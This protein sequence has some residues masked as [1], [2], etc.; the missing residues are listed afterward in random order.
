MFTEIVCDYCD[1]TK[2]KRV[3]DVNRAI[4]KG[5]KLYCDRKCAG[6]ARRKNLSDAEKKD[7]KAVYDANYRRINRDKLRAKKAEWFQRNYDP[8]KA[9]ED[10]AQRKRENPEQEAKR[11]RHMASEGYKRHKKSYDRRYRAHKKYGPEWGDC[12]VLA[13]DIRD[14]CLTQLSDADIRS[15]AGTS[16]K[17]KK[18]R[19]DY[20]RL[21]SN[22]PEIGAL[23]HPG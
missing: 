18:R 13:L 10:R 21:N 17:M 3:A 19:R 15:Q 22:K 6:L 23:G 20:E 11:R 16:N 1:K 14:E 7:Q 12:M 5:A 9:R 8:A 4:K 2:M